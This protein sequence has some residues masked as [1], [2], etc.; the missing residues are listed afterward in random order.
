MSKEIKKWNGNLDDFK[1]NVDIEIEVPLF[2]IFAEYLGYCSRFIK[3]SEKWCDG[4]VPDLHI[5]KLMRLEAL[6]IRRQML[7]D[8]TRE[9]VRTWF[10]QYYEP[11]FK[12]LDEKLSKLISVV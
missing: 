8:Y 3:M 7:K 9:E 11:I 12:E 4:E 5:Q 10:F 1:D 6:A 2:I